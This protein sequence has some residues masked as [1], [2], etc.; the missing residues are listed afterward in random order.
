MTT[1][2]ATSR[3]PGV[4][5]IAAGQHPP[6]EDSVTHHQG[7]NAQHDIPPP[8][9]S[10]QLFATLPTQRVAHPFGRPAVHPRI[11]MVDQ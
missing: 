4:G 1:T 10:S 5:I 8:G 9:A 3:N 6:P 11:P 2:E 7:R